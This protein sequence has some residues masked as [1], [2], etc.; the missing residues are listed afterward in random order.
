MPPPLHTHYLRHNK[1]ER[2]PARIMVLDTESR[3]LE[4]EPREVQAL[5]C[6]VLRVLERTEG[7]FRPK[8]CT[9]SSGTDLAAMVAAVAA[10]IKSGKPWRLYTHN[11][12]YDLGLTRLPLR[13]LEQGWELGR[14]NLASEQPWA[15]LKT[16]S[17]GLWLCDSWTWFPV[18]LE[19]L[20]EIVGLAKP[21]LPAEDDTE[22][23]WLAR[24]RADVEILSAALLRAMAE[25]DRRNLGV[26]SI[27]GPASGWNTLLHWPLRDREANRD[28]AD[29]GK[30]PAK[31]HKTSDRVLIAPDPQARSFEREALYSGRRDV[32][33]VGRLAAGPWC[34]IDLKTAHLAICSSLALPYRR[35]AAFDCLELN[36]WRL[37]H[38]KAGLVARVLV[39][40][41]T[42]RYPLRLG[43]AVLHPVGE[44]ETVLAG[45]EI[46]D[47]ATRGE[48]VS[49]GRGYG[50]HLG[51]LMKGWA[52][53]CLAVLNDT[54]G[55]I[56]PVFQPMVKGWSRTVPGRWAMLHAREVKSGPSYVKDWALEPITMGSPPRR[57]YIFHVAKTWHQSVTDQESDD[58]FPAVLA[59]IQSYCRLA[60]NRM[61]DA[62]PAGS[63]A[64][65]NTEGAWVTRN[66]V[67]SFW[68]STPGNLA[69]DIHPDHWLP[70]ALE[71]LG[72]ETAPLGVQLKS[73]AVNLEVRSPQHHRA[74]G[75]RMYSGI[76]SAALEVEPERFQFL[77]WPKLK[78][79]IQK[80]DP[81][82]YVREQ[83]K[84]SLAGLPVSRWVYQDGHCEPVE[85]RW[86]PEAG[87]AIQPPPES[88]A[89]QH[90][91]LR[92][93][94][95]PVLRRALR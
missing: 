56:D 85:V 44:F 55:E 48:V 45:P 61:L 71:M 78:G 21:A 63:I 90:G 83:R 28:F 26:W 6:W 73:T 47:A 40:C 54:E 34:E 95:H 65:C 92:A 36:D 89:S 66:A 23:A 81:R 14:H 7:D 42:P 74:D 33:Q 53:W 64:S 46:E 15:Y 43:G 5:R 94:Q 13:L 69:S 88:V 91:P 62:L 4:T 30:L 93:S 31:Q 76:P 68:S 50:Y 38:S 10:P 39:R 25:W 86:S 79:Q 52:E 20:G 49:I 37:G 82:G 58:A 1:G 60:L 72:R 22:A 75:R 3:L 70:P 19:R 57:G 11:L 84:V 59:Y 12:S 8:T 67:K 2:T 9:E 24:C 16:K 27:T 29:L 17:K 87:N 32:W 77:T 41:S 35:W 51:R 80:G 18:K